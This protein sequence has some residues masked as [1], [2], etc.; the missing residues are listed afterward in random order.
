MKKNTAKIHLNLSEK[1]VSQKKT[2]LNV[3]LEKC[4]S[5]LNFLLLLITLH[6]NN[7]IAYSQ[8][9]APLN[10]SD[11]S[12]VT[13]FTENFES[14]TL[15]EF[16]SCWDKLGSVY[17]TTNDE[18]NEEDESKALYLDTGY[19]S[20]QSIV[21]MKPLSNAGAG[22]HR[23][24]FKIKKQTSY[25]NVN[26]FV[27]IGYLTNPEDL[28]SFIKVM[29][30]N[31]EKSTY[32]EQKVNL[33]M[34]PGSNTT[35]AIR[36][37]NAG[38]SAVYI[39]DISW[40]ELPP[41]EEP[42]QLIAV[43]ITDTTARISWN[44]TG[45]LFD[46]EYG[47]ENFTMGTGALISGV[48]NPFDLEGLDSETSYSYYVRQDCGINGKSDWS[49]PYTFKT[50]CT[51]VTEFSETF[52]GVET[53]SFPS[54]W[55]KVGT[56]GMA[57]IREDE[58]IGNLALYMRSYS[59]FAKTTVKIRPVTN[60]GT[61]THRLRF[62]ARK[63]TYGLS[64]N[65]NGIIEIGYLTD[66][67]DAT[68][69]IPVSTQTVTA[70][71]YQ[72]KIA[73]LETAPGTNNVLAFRLVSA[74][75][76]YI[77][78]VIWEARP[79]CEEPVQ[80]ITSTIT[81]TS[82]KLAWTSTG[83]S[84]DIEY[85]PT[86]FVLGAGSG[87][88]VTG[89]TNNY[90]LNG[91]NPDTHYTFY[92]KQNCGTTWSEASNFQ[93]ACNAITTLPWNDSFES[94]T[95]V[96]ETQFPSC[97]R[98]EK[99]NWK[100]SNTAYYNSPRTGT[101]YLLTSASTD[102]AFIHTPAFQLEAG[103]S[104]DFIFYVQGSGYSVATVDIFST[105]NALSIPR[106][107]LGESYTIAQNSD[108]YEKVTRTFLPT[109]T[110]NY[111]FSMRLNSS[112]GFSQEVAFD[113]FTLETTSSCPIPSTLSVTNIT[114]NSAQL[115]WVGNGNNYSIEYGPKGFLSSNGTVLENVTMPYT[116]QNLAISTEYSF[117]V[118]ELCSPT[119]HSAWSEPIHFKTICGP[120]TAPT[121]V[122]TFSTYTGF[123]TGSVACWSEAENSLADGPNLHDV[124]WI[125][126]F[127]FANNDASPT[128][129]AAAINL[130]GPSQDWLISNP[131]DLGDG[132]IPFTLKYMTALTKRFSSTATNG[133]G[134]H[135][136]KVL[137]S[138][139]GGTTW[140]NSN[141]LK[142]YN[143][144]TPIS[145]TGQTE[146]IPLTGYSGI[147]KFAFYTETIDYSP[148]IHFFIDNFVV[149][150]SN[151]CNAPTALTT[152]AITSSGSTISWTAGASETAWE[153]TIQPAGTGLPT[154][155]GTTVTTSTV[156]L[157]N[158]LS[159]TSYEVYVRAI[160]SASTTSNWSGPINFT[161]QL[162]CN[163]PTAVNVTEITTTGSTISWTPGAI[164][165]TWEYTIQPVGTGIPTT[166]GIF[167]PS[168]T[169][170]LTDLTENTAYEVYVRATCTATIASAWSDP[171]QFTT[172]GNCLQPSTLI[173][174]SIT[175]SGATIAWT[176][177][178]TE[179]NWE[180]TIQPVGMG[181]PTTTG[182]NST[183]TSA[184][185]N[186]LQSDT[187][188]EVYVRA[189][190][191]TATTSEWSN[192]MVFKTLKSGGTCETAIEVNSN[193]LPYTTTDNTLNYGDHY[194]GIAGASCGITTNYLNGND[195]VYAYHATTAGTINIGLN[196]TQSNVGVFVYTAC[197]L[198]GNTCVAGAVNNAI[199][200]P[201]NINGF[202]VTAGQT[203]Y[204]VIS[205]LAP[206]QST[207]YTLTITGTLGIDSFDNQNFSYHPNPVLDILNLSYSENIT[208]VHVF[209]SIGQ[210]LIQKTV[211]ANQSQLNLSGLA[212]GT[213]FVQINAKGKIKMIKIIKQ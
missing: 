117:Y 102:N 165:T 104:Y 138:T 82:A 54:C 51:L 41:C 26:T 143:A 148:D 180:Y 120:E 139:D 77:D 166:A 203:Y 137:I 84:F 196:P 63:D 209:N 105:N 212:A 16:P 24:R 68:T 22:T 198:I 72:E 177:G 110:G 152:T 15:D 32:E 43:D 144:T 193:D 67:D 164:E 100:T 126:H 174:N 109:V 186:S 59:S 150:N 184:V 83:S 154:I 58:L 29:E 131:I 121:A 99:G 211:N 53:N 181:I 28:G 141:V 155:V 93:T 95:S 57:S 69:F 48:N 17:I 65:V 173:A 56:T 107:Q 90:E 37:T 202:T 157:D 188:Y 132:S 47:T 11:C 108:Q 12:P 62:K 195:V 185:L 88:S 64:S 2:I 20:S 205:T 118:K 134:T 179:T 147:V 33:G 76:I 125:G 91:L 25:Y 178:S 49:G 167:T 206:P 3:N 169:V 114:A 136:I 119:D 66:P 101:K 116:L 52:T 194:E 61:A 35:L 80:L 21:K 163:K 46:I 89:I 112:S 86:G 6:L 182:T 204:I 191:S 96:G 44:S 36:H 122:Q 81:P 8:N 5:K 42:S 39:D 75:G 111:Y 176:A 162:P 98:K 78:D 213:Y 168:P 31:A 113:D 73:R 71:T 197:D 94:L 10:T 13:E 153:Y 55:N 130:Y 115:S 19:Y 207:A 172:T 124:K 74:T 70:S 192:P 201:I 187:Q 7:S 158:L 106:V 208:S 60:A 183:A 145:H 129:N 27:E 92:V 45:T 18:D 1:I 142:T 170:P 200:G 210:Q 9:Y 135:I 171:V 175:T 79:A 40:E 85:G 14:Y 140:S 87:T 103:Q 128:G 127:N 146:E 161:T 159:D 123:A 160:C 4:K 50:L 190:C 133:L 38:G 156:P 151:E 149:E 34:V 97:W 23:L 30:V 199:G 189:I